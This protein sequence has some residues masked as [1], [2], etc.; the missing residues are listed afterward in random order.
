M[1]TSPTNPWNQLTLLPC[2]SKTWCLLHWLLRK[3]RSCPIEKIHHPLGEQHL[4]AQHLC[5]QRVYCCGSGGCAGP[6]GPVKPESKNPGDIPNV[7]AVLPLCPLFPGLDW[8]PGNPTGVLGKTAGVVP[9]ESSACRA[10]PWMT[11]VVPAWTAPSFPGDHSCRSTGRT[12][13]A[14]I[15]VWRRT[16]HLHRLSLLRS[17]LKPSQLCSVGLRIWVVAKGQDVLFD[18]EAVHALV[19]QQF[20]LLSHLQTRLGARIW[21]HGR[22]GL[23]HLISSRRRLW[24]TG[25]TIQA[26]MNTF[27]WLTFHAT[28]TPISMVLINDLVLSSDATLRPG[29]ALWTSCPSVGWRRGGVI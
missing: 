14:H 13:L 5:H 7:A 28:L 27:M 9:G 22:P 20:W 23:R 29:K 24:Y 10:C 11:G 3:S 19:L 4:L 8:L 12:S 18:D 15:A 2:C 21:P 26:G 16:W 6:P 1:Q 17:L 25:G